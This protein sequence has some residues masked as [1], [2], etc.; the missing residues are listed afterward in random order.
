MLCTAWSRAGVLAVLLAWPGQGGPPTGSQAP[1]LP[2]VPALDLASLAAGSVIRVARGDTVVVRLNDHGRRLGLAGI[3]VPSP[4]LPEG[5]AA[6]RF[7]DDLLA[8]EQVYVQFVG[9]PP[10]PGQH[11]RLPAYL[12]RVPD[13][14][15]INL[16]LLRR[17]HATTAADV[18]ARFAAA[19]AAYEAHARHA[20]KGRW[21]NE[22][23]AA[24]ASQT[25]PGARV[26]APSSAPSG[27]SD[28]RVYV[29]KSGKK[30]HRPECP[31]ARRGNA[32]GITLSE[33]RARGLAP[34]SRCQ[35]DQ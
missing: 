25:A 29:T 31:H 17:G 18:D 24:Q 14:L 3:D 16:E 26:T 2:P 34:C 21:G 19:F 8:G 5:A 11:E 23:A 4:A 6:L 7:L 20:A 33:A 10:A 30:Y 28:A 35:P 15:F 13:G 22:A 9:E 32:Q 1:V 12:Y 27:T